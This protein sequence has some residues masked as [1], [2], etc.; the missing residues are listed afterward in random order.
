MHIAVIGDIHGNAHALRLV[1]NDISKKGIRDLLILG[2][3]VGYYYR[4]DEVFSLLEQWQWQGVQGNHDRMLG[5]LVQ[6][7][8]SG[9]E[10]Y[11]LRYGDGLEIASRT[12]TTSQ[13]VRLTEL[14][15]SKELTYDGCR[16]LL[17]HGSP[18]SQDEYIYPDAPHATFE[19][20][21]QLGYD[22]VLL[23]HTHYPM[24][25]RVQKT[26]I[27]N[28]GSVGQPRD[29]GSMA[30]WGILTIPEREATI[31]RIRFDPA[32]IIEDARRYNPENAYLIEV[33]TREQSSHAQKT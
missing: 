28:P 19:R 1:L 10:G 16:I 21:A 27:M 7:G 12:L 14:P 2:D 24:V 6:E 22:I 9:K 25:R 17:C 5:Q 18:W 32:T 3:F 13:I 4:A 23:G 31:Q 26:L 29:F 8:G 33:L 20:I 15:E 30:S 11:R